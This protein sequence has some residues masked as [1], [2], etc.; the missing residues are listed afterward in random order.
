MLRPVEHEPTVDLVGDHPQVVLHA[1]GGQL[2]HLPTA[3]HVPRGVAR[4]VEHDPLGRAADRS[5]EGLEVGRAGAVRKGLHLDGDAAD[6]LDL[7]AVAAPGRVEQQDLVAGVHQG[8]QGVAQGVLGAVA[9][10][11]VL[12]LVGDP[13]GLLQVPGHGL[14][15]GVQACGRGVLHRAALH[16]GDGRLAGQAGGVE[17]GLADGHVDHVPARGGHFLGGGGEG[18]GDRALEARDAL[19]QFHGVPAVEKPRWCPSGRPSGTN[20]DLKSGKAG[21]ARS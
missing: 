8:E 12:G 5:A 17:V 19:T 18:E 2:L 1:D 3:P 13:P 15:Q 16:G 10:D 14:P 20:L 7:G 6:E 11:D 4:G 9:D 21:R